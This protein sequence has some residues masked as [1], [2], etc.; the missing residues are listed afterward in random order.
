MKTRFLLTTLAIMMAVTTAFAVPAKPGLKKKV[1]L[2]NG[3]TV[4]LSLKGDEHFSFYSTAEGKPCLL[5]NGELKML[6]NDEV[7][8]LWTAQKEKRLALSQSSSRRARRVGESNTTTGNHRGLVILVEFKDVKFVTPNAQTVFQ[9]FFNEEG[10]KEYGNAGSVR[11]Y[12]LK[13]SY[14]QLTID[15]DVV[16]PFAIS[17]DMEHYGKHYVD[18]SGTEQHDSHPAMMVAEAV[19]SAYK[20]GVDFS[21]YDWNGDKEVDQVF[22]IYAGYAEAQ[23]GAPETIWP[24]EW[25]LAGE[26]KTRKYNGVTINTYGCTSELMNGEGTD[27]DGIGTACHEFSHCLG[28]PDMYDTNGQVNYGM[29][30]WDV[31][32]GGS[33]NDDSHTP[34]GYTAYERWFSKWME[35]TELKEMTRING[36]K[37]LQEKAE[38]YI[39]YNEGNKNEYYILENRQPVG[40]DKGLY[41]H[42][43]LIYHVD[44][45]ESVW[46]SNKVNVSA[47]HQRM[48]IVPADNNF[49]YS[50]K[51][52]AGDPWPGTSGNTMLSNLTEPAAT[53]YNKNTDGTKF[54][55]K[56]IDNITEDEG[57]MTVS[58][59]AC[60]PEMP[61]PDAEEA[62]VQSEG[63]SF[64]ISWPAV[65]GAIG[66]EVE[67]T[68]KDKAPST[69]EQALLYEN[70][71]EKFYSK[72]TSLTPIDGSLA[73][74][75][76]EN[77]TATKLFTTPN[78]MRFGTSTTTGSLKSPWYYS[79]SSSSG[80]LVLGANIV[81]NAVKGSVSYSNGDIEGSYVKNIEQVGTVAFEVTGDQ[82][83]VVHLQDI[84]KAAFQFKIDPEAQMY[85]NYLALYDGIWTAEQLGINTASAAPRRAVTTN[86][87]TT[88]T[89]SITFADMDVNKIYIYRLRS[90]GEEGSY[91]AWSTENTFDF[92]TTG[93]RS[94]STKVTDDNTVRYFDLQGREVSGD[95]KGLLIR[96]QGSEVKKVIVK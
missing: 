50:L 88:E 76:M 21:K 56:A 36:M 92:E 30:Y 24:H 68:T 34:A 96:K 63:N 12:F 85:L 6:T 5:R 15:F 2:K 45:D 20:A 75:G 89:S 17:H 43:L 82:K 61:V 7:A 32:N 39:L 84:N 40:F 66:Y 10:Y 48:V 47:D 70:D 62:G 86:V 58:F 4:E 26:N 42:G 55:N 35:P 72:T 71:M 54:L 14:G 64:T 67:L 59:V 73:S 80:T 44:Y 41:G 74:Y 11:D 19:D 33:Y 22:V 1:T 79:P 83:L 69:P 31:M 49:T 37:P 46:K 52:F 3:T 81:K 78:K 60:R 95:T 87:Y 16:G 28:L 65:A 29:A 93:I 94:I 8:E 91:S 38:A 18:D 77:W 9:R 53:V 27:L 13:Q 25:A 23:G 90:L 51:G 57:A